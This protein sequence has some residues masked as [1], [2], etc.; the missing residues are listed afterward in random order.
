MWADAWCV[1]F[2]TVQALGLSHVHWV[3]FG[4]GWYLQPSP[5]PTYAFRALGHRVVPHEWRSHLSAF[6]HARSPCLPFAAFLAGGGLPLAPSDAAAAATA[7]AAAAPSPPRLRLPPL[8][9]RCLAAVAAAA[10]PTAPVALS[11]MAAAAAAPVGCSWCCSVATPTPPAALPCKTQGRL[12]WV[13]KR[14]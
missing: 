8:P 1:R 11:V 4:L 3:R 5:P 13:I 2:L 7:A 6:T 9:P 12:F 14:G 10:G